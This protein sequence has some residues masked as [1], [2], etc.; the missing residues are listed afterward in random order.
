MIYDRLE[1]LEKYAGIAPAAM[2]KIVDFC[3]SC[4]EIPAP[5]RYPIDETRIYA[6]VQE[7][8]PHAADPEKA[9]YHRAFADIQLLL[10]GEETLI[11]APVGEACVPY[12]AEK[13][14]GF[15][16]LPENGTVPLPLVPGNFVLLLPEERH[17]PGVGD[18]SGAVVKVVV[19]VA[20]GLLA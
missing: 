12:D 13:D 14:C 19:K 7:Y 8:A 18:P 16:R 1:N 4:A 10:A 20:A 3:R 5:G 15:D 9:E 6:M 2:K 17:L 11:C